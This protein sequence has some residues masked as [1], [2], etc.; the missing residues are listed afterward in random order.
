MRGGAPRHVSVMGLLCLLCRT[1]HVC[2]VYFL[3]IPWRKYYKIAITAMGWS[4]FLFGTFFCL[5]FS[6]CTCYNRRGRVRRRIHIWRQSRDN[7]DNH[8]IMVISKEAVAPCIF[9]YTCMCSL[10]G[11]SCLVKP[12]CAYSASRPSDIQSERF[13]RVLF[14]MLSVIGILL[15]VDRTIHVFW[16][17]F[18]GTT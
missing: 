18:M 4:L 11:D 5:L 9:S 2:W 13:R 8:V 10:V 16:V 7:G 17:Q 3:G 15:L 6:C 12:T 14:A 1:N